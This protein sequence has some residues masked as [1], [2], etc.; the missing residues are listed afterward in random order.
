MDR[1]HLPP[2][3][4]NDLPYD[5]YD[6]EGP[7]E[8]KPRFDLRNPSALAHD[9]DVEEDAVLDADN[10]GRRGQNV[11][12]S[13]VK[14]DGYDS[15]SENEG[16]K[17]RGDKSKSARDEI[18]E[19]DI[20]AELE[21]DFA[22]E[23]EEEEDHSNRKSVRFLEDDEIQGQVRSSKGGKT[24]HASDQ[25]DEEESSDESEVGEAERARLDVDLDKELGAGAKKKNAPLL[26]GFNMQNEQEDGRFDDAGNFVRN[27]R[28][29]DAV[30][31]QWLDGVSKK[32]IRK[33]REAADKREEKILEKEKRDDSFLTAD[34][35][36]TLITNME[37]TETILEALARL[38]KGIKRKPKWQTK[39]KNKK[40][41]V[42]EDIEMDEDNS[43]ESGRKKAIEALTGAA[44][45]LMHRGQPDI[46][47]L[48]RELLTRQYRKE[49]GNDW[50]D[51]PSESSKADGQG[52]TMWEYRWSDARDGGDA[53][54]PYDS[55][56][57]D[58]WTSAGY[59]GE[60][61]EFRQVGNTGPWS[62]TARFV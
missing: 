20:A 13:A 59:F 36:K 4:G 27:A 26:D 5:R 28:D 9:D 47:D 58:S 52:P 46:Y 12:R 6:D 29:P 32:E 17:A 43:D 56:M 10:I 8:K 37:R 24:M 18:D 40:S 55:V 23:D 53:H 31:D 60:G 38:G 61:V 7:S 54:G 49:T 42:V 19:D 41:N 1:S 2:K 62:H 30:Y 51:P 16:F 50:I 48:E 21:A 25:A 35:L 11:R 3:R 15:D 33:A 22:E 45:I 39:K 34:V 44:D 14:L 57:M